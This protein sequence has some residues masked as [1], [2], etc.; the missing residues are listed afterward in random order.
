MKATISIS[1]IPGTTGE[2][3]KAKCNQLLAAFDETDEI[4]FYIH[5]KA[6]NPRQIPHTFTPA[7]LNSQSNSP[8]RFNS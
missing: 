5:F 3:I 4:D 1:C 6:L 7:E 2:E 8:T